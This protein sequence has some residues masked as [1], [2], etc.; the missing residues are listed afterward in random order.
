[1][2]RFIAYPE[3][4][5]EF[6]RREFSAVAAETVEFRRPVYG[7]LLDALEGKGPS[8]LESEKG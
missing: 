8:F 2:P 7:R 6:L 1:M 3:D 4:D 5:A